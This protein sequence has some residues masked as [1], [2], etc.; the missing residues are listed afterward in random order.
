[1]RLKRADYSGGHMA[2]AIVLKDVRSQNR[3]I[4]G[5]VWA[6]STEIA[7]QLASY[8]HPCQEDEVLELQPAE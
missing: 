7:H 5:R 2:F 4:V 6:A 8:F 3:R 1:M